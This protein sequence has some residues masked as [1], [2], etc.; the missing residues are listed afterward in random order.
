MKL[1]NN[2][3]LFI[4]HSII[5]LFSSCATKI[6]FTS[7]LKK[8]NNLQ[9]ED[10]KQMQFYLSDNIILSNSESSGTKN[11]DNKGNLILNN[12]YSLNK[13]IIKKGTKGVVEKVISE[14]M[15]LVSFEEGNFI[16]FGNKTGIG[17]YKLMSKKWNNNQAEVE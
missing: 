8:Q 4:L 1:F 13:I 16:V 17:R 3:K 12:K 5:F 14:D 7:E 10:I 6:P 11:T 2:N 9:E 15:F